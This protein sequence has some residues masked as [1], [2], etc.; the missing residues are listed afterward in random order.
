MRPS[1]AAPFGT[2][3]PVAVINSP[4]SDESVEEP[5]TSALVERATSALDVLLAELAQ[6]T[7]GKPRVS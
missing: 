2:S 4:Q 6:A 1:P 5:S 3:A 7:A